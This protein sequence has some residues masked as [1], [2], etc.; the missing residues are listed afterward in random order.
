MSI[1]RTALSVVLISVCFLAAS[2]QTVSLG[3]ERP[4][5]ALSD[6]AA[7]AAEPAQKQPPAVAQPAPPAGPLEVGVQDSILL[8][9]ENNQGLV[10]E[11][12]NP[13]ITRTFENEQEAAFD[14]TLSGQ[15]AAGRTEAAAR[16]SNGP[17][18]TESTV[19]DVSGGVALAK[20][21]PSGTQIGVQGSSEF[22]DSSLYSDQLVSSRLGLSVTQALL[23]GAGSSVNLASVRQARLDTL[24]S[25]Y[26]LRGFTEDLVARSEETYWDYV[27]AQR[28]IEIY[29]ESL[30]LAEKQLADTLE[31]IKVGLLAESESAAARAEVA[32][33]KQDLI[34]ARGNLSTTHLR[35]LRLL[36][37]PDGNWSR[38]IT[39]RNQPAVP[40]AKLDDVGSHVDVAL[41]MR[42]DLNQALLAGERGD[43]ELVKTKNGLLPKMDLFISLGGTGYSDSFGSSLASHEASGFDVLAGLRMEYPLGNR[44][45]RARH[46]RATLGRLQATEAVKNLEQLIQVD[47]RSAYVQ[48]NSAKEQVAATAASR[49]AQDE[50]VRAETEKFKVGKSTSLLVAHAQR[51][52]VAARIAEI[53]TVV[54]YLKSL[55]ELY[56]LEGSLLERRGISA[57]GREPAERPLE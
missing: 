49:V 21:L 32:L 44:A 57:P 30:S 12:L 46:E 11:R 17:G 37:P 10:L 48:V 51:D 4:T 6:A 5:G 54:N 53:Q 33:R 24:V 52:L 23:K 8:A 2:C 55:V 29:T 3:P 13:E 18:V 26:E 39:P 19:N 36:N 20:T 25:E 14:P 7:P 22:N 40:D 41:R 42:P 16:P 47:V 27:L 34:I 50:N 1:K 43:L 9:L 15:V 56:R 35:L 45:A 28:Q 38:E 31:Q